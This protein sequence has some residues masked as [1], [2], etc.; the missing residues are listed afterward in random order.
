MIVKGTINTPDGTVQAG[1]M[2]VSKTDEQCEICLEDNTQLLLF[3]GKPLADEP[4]LMWNFVAYDKERLT[5]A[6]Q[7]WADKKFPK[8]P[9]DD[10]Y[11]PFS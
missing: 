6:K 1:Q 3:G 10:T 9:G 8:V 7:D 11:I 5:K 4:L 2:L